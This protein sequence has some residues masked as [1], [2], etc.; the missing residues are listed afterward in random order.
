MDTTERR[1]R[2][3]EEAAH[4]WLQLQD[5]PSRAEREEFVDWLRES[6]LHVA[7]MLR[8]AQV[9]GALEQFKRW[10]ALPIERDND[11]ADD[12]VIP[13]ADAPRPANR[14]PPRTRSW[15]LAAGLCSIFIVASTLWMHGRGKVISTERG[16][17]REVA[18]ADGSV[19]QMDPET[20]LRV[21]YRDEE[22]RVYLDRGRALFRVAKNA[23][24]PFLVEARDTTVRAV[25]TAFGVEYEARD[26]IVTVAEGRVAIFRTTDSGR[27]GTA[28]APLLVA[29]QQI[30]VRASAETEPVRAV[31]SG[32]ALAWAQGRLI[33][34]S[35]TVEEAV[36]Q[37]NRYNRIQIR[38]ADEQLA[39]RPVSG[40][41][42]AADPESFVAF[43]RSVVPVKITRDDAADITIFSQR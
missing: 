21:K 18:L 25:G 36:R 19:V 31:D 4:W 40:V 17:R 14:T 41:F 37:F 20:T 15:V 38:I 32:K 35:T 29:D 16:E 24:R 39:R 1:R 13:I 26:V 43:I 12:N 2:A 34:E 27:D 3:G 7:E 28:A 11:T 33:F 9:H 10:T 23:S 8:I 22:R 6:P 5:A 42:S 30:T